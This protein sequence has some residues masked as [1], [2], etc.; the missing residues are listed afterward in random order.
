MEVVIEFGKHKGQKLGEIPLGYLRWVS[1]KMANEKIGKIA[2]EAPRQRQISTPSRVPVEQQSPAPGDL[3]ISI[4]GDQDHEIQLRRGRHVQER[5][6]VVEFASVDLCVSALRGFSGGIVEARVLEERVI[7]SARVFAANRRYLS[8]LLL[9]AYGKCGGG[10]SDAVRIFTAMSSKDHYSWNTMLKVFLDNHL[11]LEA[12]RLFNEMAPGVAN[13]IACTAMISLYSSQGRVAD[14]C[15]AFDRILSPDTTA[16]N[17]LMACFMRNEVSTDA[18]TACFERIPHKDQVSWNLL[19][20]GLGRAGHLAFQKM[21][22]WDLVALNTLVEKRG[23]AGERA[24]EESCDL[25]ASEKDIVSWALLLREYA[26][27]G[28]LEELGTCFF[29]MPCHNEVVATLVPSAFGKQGYVEA[30]KAVFDRVQGF[31]SW[32]ALVT[33]NSHA[34]ELGEAEKVFYLMPMWGI[35]SSTAIM[36]VY[37]RNDVV[38]KCDWVFS[39]LMQHRDATTWTVL[40]AAYAH[41]G[42]YVCARSVLERMPMAELTSWN[43]MLNSEREDHLMELFNEMPERDINSWTLMVS[44]FAKRRDMS[45]A[46]KLLDLCPAWAA[47]VWNAVISG[48]GRHACV[49]EAVGTFF[50]MLLDGV[51]PDSVTFV[52][53]LGAMSFAGDLEKVRA[54]FL[55]LRDFDIEEERRHYYCVIGALARAGRVSEAEE[56]QEAMPFTADTGTMFALLNASKLEG[57]RKGASKAARKVMSLKSSNTEV[58]MANILLSHANKGRV[59][60]SFRAG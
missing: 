50:K 27:N 46:L 23:A 4:P 28:Q 55:V 31:G 8:N 9:L 54:W 36:S 3:L 1:T 45:T 34:G 52:C 33:A 20:A 40:I 14:A 39:D 11:W 56:L 22:V 37:A 29:K 44:A 57:D 32:T 30:A 16:W 7:S 21:P 19:L 5:T 43:A 25:R 41:S 2:M 26:H 38:D 24:R 42:Y 59:T 51:E 60:F 35:E 13:C 15:A 10:V 18:L 6:G 58:V 17:A 12:E 47:S 48:Y 53:L 49:E